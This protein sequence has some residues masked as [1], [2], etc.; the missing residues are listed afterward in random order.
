MW[1][2]LLA[3]AVLLGHHSG[4]PDRDSGTV[5]A[6]TTLAV[7]NDAS[8][9]PQIRDAVELLESAGLGNLLDEARSVSLPDWLPLDEAADEGPR[10]LAPPG[11][12]HPHDVL[13][14]GGR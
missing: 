11:H 12:V 3:A 14:A 9:D 2:A 1:Q 10:G 5:G 8:V 7:L 13:R 6:S 4:M